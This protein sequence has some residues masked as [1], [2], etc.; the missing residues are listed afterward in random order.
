MANVPPQN[1]DI[2]GDAA[3]IA[4]AAKATTTASWISKQN[5]QLLIVGAVAVGWY[6]GQ[7]T[8]KTITG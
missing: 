8:R 5:P 2:K 3:R 7:K 6:L 4:A 1:P